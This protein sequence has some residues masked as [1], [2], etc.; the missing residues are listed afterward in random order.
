M[1][2]NPFVINGYEGPEFFC[3]RHQETAQLINELTNGNN[4]ALVAPRRMGKSGLICH[5]FQEEIISKQYYTFYIDIY[6]T[7]S[8][9]ELVFRMSKEILLRL[10][11]FGLRVMQEFWECV[12]SLQAGISFSPSGEPTFSLQVGDIV[13][14]ENTLDEI[15]HYLQNADRPCIVAI[16]EFQQISNYKDNKVEAL[17]RTYIQQYPQVRFI[18][19]GSQRHLITQMFTSPSRPFYQ[20]VSMMHLDSLGLEEYIRFAKQHFENAGKQLEDGVVESVFDLAQGTTW[21]I[22]KL[23]N[24]LYSQTPTSG[25]CSKEMVKPAMDYILGTLD[26]GYKE[27]MYRIPDKQGLV[28]IALGKEGQTSSV[29]SGA[30][31]RKYHLNSASTVQSAIRG[32][33][34]NDYITQEQGKYHIY[35]IFLSYWLQQNY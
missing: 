31:I 29:T 15:F 2:H 28:L 9:Q 19:A 26:Y 16:D 33:L 20:S 34:D 18:F 13:H 17:L 1:I 12:R 25:I 14:S 23:M 4:V 32:L 30:F 21:Y 27:M 8:L 11:P 10:K 3:G 6:A 5:C 35:D 24:T 7:H 22:Q